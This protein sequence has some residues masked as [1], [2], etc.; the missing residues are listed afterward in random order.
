MGSD[1]KT[2]QQAI[3]NFANGAAAFVDF[4]DGLS[5]GASVFASARRAFAKASTRHDRLHDRKLKRAVEDRR[6]ILFPWCPCNSGLVESQCCY[7]DE[8]PCGSGMPKERCHPE[9]K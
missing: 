1:T 6:S 8:C 2:A 3:L 5:S 9:V 7:P 4:L